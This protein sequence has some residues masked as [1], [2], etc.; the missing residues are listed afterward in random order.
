M[1]VVDGPFLLFEITDTA[2]SEEYTV[3]RQQWVRCSRLHFLGL[4]KFFWGRFFFR[5]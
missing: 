5:S 1:L 2:G 4:F 3:M